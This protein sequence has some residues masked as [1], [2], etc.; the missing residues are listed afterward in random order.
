MKNSPIH[1]SRGVLEN[2]LREGRDV[3]L[4][5]LYELDHVTD[6]SI[7]LMRPNGLIRLWPVGSRLPPEHASRRLR[8]MKETG[9]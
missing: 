7:F 5:S 1:I 2:L 4:A 6:G 3:T 8:I 9:K